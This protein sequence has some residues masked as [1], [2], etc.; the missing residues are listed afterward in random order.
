M[1]MYFLKVLRFFKFQSAAGYFMVAVCL[2]LRR[3]GADT[4]AA[5]SFSS[6]QLLGFRFFRPSSVRARDGRPVL[7]RMCTVDPGVRTVPAITCMDG[8]GV[9]VLRSRQSGVMIVFNFVG[10]MPP[11]S[12]FTMLVYNLYYT[13]E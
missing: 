11:I 4:A 7:G 5:V 12:I 8:R 2:L 6:S 9:Q 3:A 10:T 13:E 1:A